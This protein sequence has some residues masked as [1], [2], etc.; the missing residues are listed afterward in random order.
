MKRTVLLFAGLAVLGACQSTDGLSYKLYP[1]PIRPDSELSIVRLGDAHNVRIDG[2]MASRADWAEARLLPG[3]HAIWWETE[4]PGPALFGGS[5]AELDDVF[6]LM[7]GHIYRLKI[8]RAS[9]HIYLTELRI[10]DLT[11]GDAATR[12]PKP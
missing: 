9:G 5:K 4:L 12:L 8:A 1:G 7:P 6:D 10:D 2:L 3:E 11:T